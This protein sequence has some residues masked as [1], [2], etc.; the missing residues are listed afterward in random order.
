MLM[1][2]N[3]DSADTILLQF[4]SLLLGYCASFKYFAHSTT[5]LFKTEPCACCREVI[6]V[7]LL[8]TSTARFRFTDHLS[9]KTVRHLVATLDTHLLLHGDENLGAVRFE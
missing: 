4:N 3:T 5:L 2:S 8:V 9:P 7:V 6:Y 1:C